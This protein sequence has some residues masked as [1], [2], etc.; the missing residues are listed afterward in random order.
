MCSSDLY[1]KA[2][3]AITLLKKYGFKVA[4][5]STFNKD[6]ICDIE[7]I[8]R[9]VKELGAMQITYGLTMDV[10]RAASN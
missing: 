2:C 5:S 4:I 1:E 9:T 10:G 6:N 3:N 7:E 8:T